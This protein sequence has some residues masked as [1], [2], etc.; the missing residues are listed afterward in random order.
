LTL[1][2]SKIQTN[3]LHPHGKNH[4]K[5]IFIKFQDGL[6]PD[7][8]RAWTS[9]W[10]T[11]F[12]QNY[13]GK[14][15]NILF[16]AVQSELAF[17]KSPQNK[18]DVNVCFFLTTFLY[19]KLNIEQ[20]KDKAFQRGMNLRKTIDI[21]HDDTYSRANEYKSG[22]IDIMIMFASNKKSTA[23]ALIKSIK[24]SLEKGIG[25]VLIEEYGKVIRKKGTD[26]VF[27][28]FGFKDSI[29]KSPDPNKHALI[30]EEN[31]SDRLGSYFV[32]RKLRQDKPLFDKNINNLKTTGGISRKYA[33]AQV[34]GR[35]KD[36]LPIMFK[37]HVTPPGRINQ[38][39]LDEFHNNETTI[40]EIEEKPGY[41]KCPFHAHIRKVK[42]LDAKIVRRGI[43]Y[44]RMKRPQIGKPIKAEGLLF[45][46]YQK[47]IVTQFEVIQGKLSMG[48]N[49][50]KNG[51]GVDP[52]AKNSRR[53]NEQP[54]QNEQTWLMDNGNNFQYNFEQT[55]WLEGGEYFY[56]PSIP[57]LVQSSLG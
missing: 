24:N 57:F 39:L 51:T 54:I 34:I 45:M 42:D 7:D 17:K 52:L 49:H 28:P 1:D 35:Y 4:V 11:K 37:N 12:Q 23:T 38:N 27:E 36:G 13:F 26:G 47:S 25:S 40:K 5:C 10:A 33:E 56:A 46:C 20:P 55:V 44:K 19:K 2:K 32:F 9:I 16:S 8:I 29:S 31:H 3:I 6:T 22:N 15:I 50:P 43:P 30:S 14:N 18:N 21:L 53:Q 48:L 41:S